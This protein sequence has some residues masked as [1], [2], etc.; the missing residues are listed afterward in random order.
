MHEI[1]FRGK[2]KD[3]GEWVYGYYCKYGFT[4]QEKH[5]IIPTF[6]SALYV[7]D[8]IPETVGQDTGLNDENG[9]RIFKGDI[10]ED[11]C[12][13]IFEVI[14]DD[15]N[16]RFLGRHSKPRG[17]TYIC[18]VGREPKCVVIGNI[19]DNPELLESE[20]DTK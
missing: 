14:W 15:E 19:H 5:Y 2:R 6:A 11:S 13:W 20:V 17:D 16:G 9:K 4:G 8:V 1:L 12:G 18:Y 3:N 7:F 10:L